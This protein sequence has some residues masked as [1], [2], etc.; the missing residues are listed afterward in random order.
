[1]SDKLMGMLNF[2]NVADS[3]FVAA[4]EDIFNGDPATDVVNLAKF[5]S[6][7]F[8]I[9]KNAG[10][11]G[12]ATIT[13]ES[14]DNVTPSVTTAIPFHYKVSTTGNV[15]GVTTAASASGFTTT[16]G[17]NQCYVIEVSADELS[18]TNQ[19][20]RMKCTEVRN[21]ACDGAILCVLGRARYPADVPQAAIA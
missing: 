13:I 20:V 21:Y 4:N 18:G 3:N 1:M 8:I 9:V 11:N 17:A 6:V 5:E 19:F 2:Y 14:C 15:W 12:N 16:V 10:A 7:I